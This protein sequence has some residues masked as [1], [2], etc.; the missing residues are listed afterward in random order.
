MAGR[1]AYKEMSGLSSSVTSYIRRLKRVFGVV[2]WSGA[3]VKREE[4]SYVYYPRHYS[5]SFSRVRS[6]C[7]NVL[8]SMPGALTIDQLWISTLQDV[9]QKLSNVVNKGV[10]PFKT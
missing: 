5:L 6:T 9:I 7:G 10:E 2:F 3:A 1:R 8:R 4:K